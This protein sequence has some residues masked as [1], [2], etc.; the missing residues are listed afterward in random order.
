MEE[1]F[2]IA[3][4][5]LKRAETLSLLSDILENSNTD[6]AEIP[7]LQQTDDN[8]IKFQNFALWALKRANSADIKG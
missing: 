6:N 3:R 5:Q 2:Q 4:D 8:L 7:I 1:N